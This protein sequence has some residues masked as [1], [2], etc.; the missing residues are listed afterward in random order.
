LGV[1]DFAGGITIH[2]TAGVGSLVCALVMGRRQ[3]FDKYHGEFPAHNLPL[4]AIGAGM[5]AVGKRQQREKKG[6][7]K[8][9]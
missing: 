6:R 8:K 3:N 5:L 9:F 1:L 2:T 7:K 4:A